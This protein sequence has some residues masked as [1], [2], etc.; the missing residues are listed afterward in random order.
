MNIDEIVVLLLSMYILW[1]YYYEN[2]R[3]EPEPMI[4]YLPMKVAIPIDSVPEDMVYGYEQVGY[5]YSGFGG[6]TE[7]TTLDDGDR[8]VTNDDYTY[9]NMI[10]LFGKRVNE[11]WN[12][13]IK[14]DRIY[15]IKVPLINKGQDCGGINGCPELLNGDQVYMRNL[16]KVFTVRLFLRKE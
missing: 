9:D 15:N 12:Y 10:P 4:K 16:N 7:E 14:T 8:T 3:P 11:S 2:T 1:V 5:L 13:Y 6:I